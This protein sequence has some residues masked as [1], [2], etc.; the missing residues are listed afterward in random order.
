[1][2]K[3]SHPAMF[4]SSREALGSLVPLLPPLARSERSRATG[5]AGEGGGGRG[6]GGGRRAAG[7]P[8][9]AEARELPGARAS[10]ARGAERWRWRRRQRAQGQGMT[11]APSACAYVR[12][13]GKREGAC[14]ASLPSP[15]SLG[16]LFPPAPR[17]PPAPPPSTLP[18]FPFSA[19][20]SGLC[21]RE[22]GE[23]GGGGGGGTKSSS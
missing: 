7:R 4:H 19:L 22:E 21:S 14:R 13:S 15:L 9:A 23:G 17:F 11:D 20:L 5:A 16:S 3:P 10:C 6:A 18:A 2:V 1:M 12:E 8:A